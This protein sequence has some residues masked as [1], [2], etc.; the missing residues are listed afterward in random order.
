MSPQDSFGL[1]HSKAAPAVERLTLLSSHFRKPLKVVVSRNLGP[2]VMPLLEE[3]KE[4]N[5]C[6]RVSV[7]H[8][9][10]LRGIAC[11]MAGRPPL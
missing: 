8:Y 6:D 9:I 2:D 10:E 11:R 5:V 7:D 1:S 3:R 4:L